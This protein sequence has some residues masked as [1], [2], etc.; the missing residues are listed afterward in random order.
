MK[1][2]NGTRLLKIMHNIPLVD[3][4]AQY[5]SIRSELD[6]AIQDTIEN[7]AFIMGERVKDFEKE[8]AKFCGAK[9]G[10]GCSSGTTALHLALMGCGV[11]V[12]DEVIVPSHT[13]VATAGAVCHCGATPVFVDVDPDIYTMDPSNL[14]EFITKKTKAIIPVHLYGQSADMAPIIEIAEKYDLKTVEDCAQAHGA[15]YKGRPVGTVGDFGAFSFFPGKNLGAYG[16]GGMVTT[17][18]EAMARRLRMLCDHG[19]SKK[20]EHEIIGYNYR[21]DALQAA[22]L[23]VKLRYLGGWLEARRQH[24]H[25]YNNLLKDLPVQTPVE[26]FG[27]VYHLYVIQCE[28]RDGLANALR[29]KGIETGIHYPIP[30][31]LQPCFR[32]LPTAGLGKSPITERLSNRILSLPIFPELTAGQQDRVA[33]ALRGFFEKQ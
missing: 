16:D 19:R 17:N 8:F 7:T 5:R 22:I 23:K 31:H 18:D 20:Y 10:I 2:F 11:G 25:R 13:F 15:S 4:R 3:L 32:G 27:H 29:A 33:G 28:D 6:S 30:L 24:A 14:E 1:L 9:F 26:K 12:G 21:L